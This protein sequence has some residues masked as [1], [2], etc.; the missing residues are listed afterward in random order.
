VDVSRVAAARQSG[1]R[2]QVAAVAAHHLDDED[3]SLCAL[4]EEAFLN[5]NVCLHKQ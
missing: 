2:R 1:H 3:A 4:Q 5:L